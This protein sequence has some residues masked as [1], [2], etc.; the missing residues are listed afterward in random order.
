M[1]HCGN[2]SLP[3]P[4]FPRAYRPQCMHGI[5]HNISR[6]N[7]PQQLISSEVCVTMSLSHP[8]HWCLILGENTTSLVQL[9]QPP[10]APL[11][12]STDHPGPCLLP[13]TS[14]PPSNHC[15]CP[16]PPGPELLMRV[17]QGPVPAGWPGPQPCLGLT[18]FSF[19]HYSPKRKRSDL[20]F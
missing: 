2:K 4:A 8:T 9:Y 20:T 5:G 10:H 19:S 1:S 18:A 7:T 16:L 11:T 15:H 17:P 12:L 6:C 13:L 3:H 14:P